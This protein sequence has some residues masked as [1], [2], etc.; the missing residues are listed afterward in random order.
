MAELQQHR[1]ALHPTNEGTASHSNNIT[2]AGGR[3]GMRQLADSGGLGQ[4]SSRLCGLRRTCGW[5]QFEADGLPRDRVYHGRVFD[6]PGPSLLWGGHPHGAVDG[7][8]RGLGDSERVTWSVIK[9]QI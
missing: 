8:Q 2:A 1:P 6:L 4:S 5:D 3:L 7:Q 9:Q